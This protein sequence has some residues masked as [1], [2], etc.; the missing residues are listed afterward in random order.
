MQPRTSQATLYNR[1]HAQ[2]WDP[3][4]NFLAIHYKYNT[5]LDTPFWR[6]C[7]EKTDLADG[8][9]IVEY[10]RENGPEAYWGPGLIDNPHD[11]FNVTGYFQLLAG[12][13]VPYRQT[14]RPSPQ[15]LDR[16]NQLRRANRDAALRCMTVRDVLAAVRSPS[17]NI[18]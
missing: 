13:K 6:E 5:R 12:M 9:R 7:R 1:M 4:R 11:Q 17:A 15:E 8:A 2:Y 18:V 3:I 14:Y 10:Y 16:F